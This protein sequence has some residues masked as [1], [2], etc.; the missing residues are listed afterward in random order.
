MHDLTCLGVVDAGKDDFLY[1]Y[2]LEHL[3]L[4]CSSLVE[5]PTHLHNFRPKAISKLANVCFR[6]VRHCHYLSYSVRCI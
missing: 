5:A 3:R 6:N 2:P 4:E 1:M